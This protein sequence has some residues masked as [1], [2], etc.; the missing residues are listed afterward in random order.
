MIGNYTLVREAHAELTHT[1][2]DGGGNVNKNVPLFLS[3]LI[4]VRTSR[5]LFSGCE[6][7]RDELW[8]VN[9]WRESLS[10]A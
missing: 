5:V 1:L 4:H 9:L 8:L 6:I 7:R 10:L 3:L 2:G